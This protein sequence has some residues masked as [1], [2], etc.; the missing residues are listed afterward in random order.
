MTAAEVVSGRSPDQ[1]LQLLRVTG[2]LL[3]GHFILTS[4]LHSG[5]YVQCAKVLQYPQHAETLGRWMAES[6]HGMAVEGVISP[7]IGGNFIWA[8]DAPGLRGG[9][10]FGRGGKG[11][12]DL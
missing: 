12:V 1:V 8:G 3:E 11:G 6:L 5:G 10:T 7:A 9:A 2:A 4:G